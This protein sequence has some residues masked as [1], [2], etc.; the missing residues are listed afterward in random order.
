MNGHY[1]IAHHQKKKSKKTD[2]NFS[3]GC[4]EL[5]RSFLF[6]SSLFLVQFSYVL[7]SCT[8]LYFIPM[9]PFPF[10][11][12]HYNFPIF[13]SSFPFPFLF[14]FPRSYIPGNVIPQ[15]RSLTDLLKSSASLR[16]AKSFLRFD[17]NDMRFPEPEGCLFLE[18]DSL[19]FCNS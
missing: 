7:L 19:R 16:G 18:N 10:L 17:M 3:P 13:P 9:F 14:P 2:D 11:Y 8:F 6:A 4:L 5:C 15:Y 1:S 12:S